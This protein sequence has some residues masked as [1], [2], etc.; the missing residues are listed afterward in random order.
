MEKI[1]DI[2]T[3]DDVV[4]GIDVMPEDKTFEECLVE[5]EKV[6]HANK[7]FCAE[8]AMQIPVLHTIF[9]PDDEKIKAVLDY[10]TRI[11]NDTRRIIL[12]N[13]NNTLTNLIELCEEFASQ[14]V[15]LKSGIETIIKREGGNV[16]YTNTNKTE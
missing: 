7:E 11:Q 6:N 14:M 3:Q 5:A 9:N 13:I 8:S 4:I 2:K 16:E 10:A 15:D 1:Y 12:R